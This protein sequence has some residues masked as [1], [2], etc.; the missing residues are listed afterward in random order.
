[1]KTTERGFKRAEFTDHYGNQYSIQES[2]LATED[3]IWFG[4]NNA[5][6]IRMEPGRGWQPYPIPDDVLLHTRMHLTREMVA[7]LLPLLQHFVE[8][9]ELPG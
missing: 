9:G 3:A 8:T 7:A 5:N 1:M 2:S 4:I 6:P